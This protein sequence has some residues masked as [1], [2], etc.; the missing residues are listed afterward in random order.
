M[1]AGK[2]IKGEIDCIELN[3]GGSFTTF[4]EDYDG[5][6][7]KNCAN[8]NGKLRS[9]PIRGSFWYKQTTRYDCGYIYLYNA[10]YDLNDDSSLS[11][12][13][14]WRQWLGKYEYLKWTEMMLKQTDK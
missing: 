10:N 3:I 13:P 2:R 14:Q 5:L 11:N 12:G 8:K 6:N 9:E 7:K 4:D 1:Q